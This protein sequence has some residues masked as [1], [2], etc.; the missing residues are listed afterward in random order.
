MEERLYE[1]LS[2]HLTARKRN[3]FDQIASNRT[4]YITLVMED[5]YQAQNTSAIQRSAESWGIQDLYVIEN[6]HAFS[7][8]R[9]IAR[10]AYDW[11]NVHRFNTSTNNTQK[12]FESLREKGY[13]I[14]VTALH[15][16][17]IPL[18]EIDLS[19]K[20]AV[21]MGTELT[22]ASPAA[23]D[24]ADLFIKIPTYGFTESL[25]VSAASSV[26]MHY[27]I[28]RIRQENQPWQLSEAEK[29]QLKIEWAKKTIYWSKYLIDM[30]ESGEL[31]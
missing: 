28:E 5:L 13:Q 26:I 12:C 4:R 25:N 27:L 3:L 15:A 29:L 11:L 7:H 9:R 30:Y 8:H 20:T 31:K 21:V 1:I 2:E 23:M 17:T 22:G 24:L 14:A 19:K 18:H 10:G 6:A 16:D